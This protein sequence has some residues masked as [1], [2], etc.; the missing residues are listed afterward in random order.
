M[1][2]ACQVGNQ[3]E[4]SDIKLRHSDTK[5]VSLLKCNNKDLRAAEMVLEENHDLAIAKWK[6]YFGSSVEEGGND[7]N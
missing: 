4:D 3:V 5:R 7:E 2:K 1:V 6:E